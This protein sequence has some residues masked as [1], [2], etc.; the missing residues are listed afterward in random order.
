MTKPYLLVSDIH[1]HGWSQFSTLLP[2]GINS[3]LKIINDELLRASRVLE[4]AGGDQMIF[5]GDLFHT[6]GSIDPEVF[7]PTFDTFRNVSSLDIEIDA[8]PGNH[9][10]KGKETSELGNAMQKLGAIPGMV[11]HTGPQLITH[12]FGY[13]LLVPW[14]SKVDD[15][16]RTLEGQ[17]A[18]HA[19]AI[20]ATDLI[21]HAGIDGVIKGLP[22]HGLSSSY[23][24]SLGFRRVFAG[25]YHDHKVMEGG[26]VISIGA[27]THQ[28]FSDIGAKAGFLLVYED[29]VEYHASHA[30]SFIEINENTPEE[31]IPLIV[32][33]N[34]V[35]VRG[36]KM[37]DSDAQELRKDLE[38]QGAAGI[39]I[40]V[41]RQVV[42]AR[43]T[44][45]TKSRTLTE[46]VMDYVDSLKIPGGADIKKDC[47]DVLATVQSVSP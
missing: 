32:P 13:A 10:L 18:A 14:V 2:D 15:L 43:G 29:R 44:T 19:A 34:Y 27:T 42:Q 9:D 30:P 7:N 35:R 24:A 12:D 4:S 38:R 1:A 31:D 11:V 17:V 33:G 37:T 36:L 28:T 26:K 6:R 41:A 21:I 23:L 47:A 40:E 8:V 45:T 39:S 5:A 16:K 22:D 20:G 25:H 46:S 3:R